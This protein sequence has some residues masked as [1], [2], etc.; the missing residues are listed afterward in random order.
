VGI[1]AGLRCGRGG[2]APIS[3]GYPTPCAFSGTLHRVVVELEDDGVQDLPAEYQGA[4][5]DE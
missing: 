4:L 1:T 5:A 2:P 3:D